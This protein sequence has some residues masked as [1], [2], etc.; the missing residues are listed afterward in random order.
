MLK[1][2]Q[3]T[4]RVEGTAIADDCGQLSEQNAFQEGGKTVSPLF[5]LLLSML[6]MVGMNAQAQKQME[7]LGRGVVAVRS[8]S[9][10]VYVSWRMFGTD[11]SNI[12]FN[13]YRGTTKL[14]ASPITNSTNYVDN[15]STN[16]T[17]SVRPVINGV[18]QTASAS[19]SVWGQ[20]F[21]SIPIQIPAGGSNASGAYTYA[22]G[23]ASVGDLDG[24]GEYEIVLKWDPSNA[25]DNSQS[26]YTGNVYIDAYKLNGT[27]LWR[28][29]LGRN[30]RAGAHYTQLMV[31]DLDGDGKAEI[32][33]KTGDGTRDGRGTVI[34]NANADYRNSSGYILTGPEYLTIFNG[35]TGA[36]MATTAHLPARGDVC[37]W[38][39]NECYGNRVDRFVSAVAYLD[40]QRPSLIIG[41]GYYGK[42]VRAAYDW[43]N[44]QLTRRWI[45]DSSASGNSAYAGQGNHQ[46]SV[47]DVDGDG[48]DEVV[49][50]SSVID[51]NGAG[52]WSNRLGHG[53]ALH[54]SDMDP[55]RPGQEI[56]MPYESPSSNGGTGMALVNASNGSIIWRVPVA[57]GDIGR[58]IAADIDPRHKGYEM[59]GATGNLYN[60]KGAQI[61]TTKPSMNFAIWWDG[62]LS[63]EILDGTKLD[64]WN[65]NTNSVDRLMTIYNYGTATQINGTKANPCLSAD[66]LGD[67][68]EEMI[69]RS[70]DNTKLL[71]FTTT[72]PTT[73]RIYTLM[74]DPQYRVAIAWQNTAY[75][76]PPHPGFYLGTGMAAAPRPNI[77]LVGDGPTTN[78]TGGITSGATYTIAARH[79]GQ[80]VDVAGASTA[81]GANIE[82]YPS[83]NGTNQQ[84]VVTST[85]DGYYTLKAVHSGRNLT[86]EGS[87]TANG[88]NIAQRTASAS[89]TNQQF[90]LVD[91]GGGYYNIKAR[92]SGRCVDVVEASTANSANINQWACG[93]GTNQQFSFTKV[94]GARLGAATATL[95]NVSVHP[96]PSSS[97]FRIQVIGEFSY[98]VYDQ[99]G[100][101]V[102]SGKGQDENSVGSN[103]PKGLYL[104]KIQQFNQTKQVKVIKQ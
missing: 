49:N 94:G 75:N 66:L 103:L 5:I 4:C 104:I 92:H 61:S 56:W 21:L 59:W 43:R 80:V 45:F 60:A 8:S 99:L 48:R 88:A 91:V 58:G 63:R 47:G 14:N 23:D 38:G 53:D 26:G 55:D 78:P 70:A 65:P 64:K 52:K 79:S 31:Y 86:V 74:H 37:S 97:T 32:A 71:L 76:Q 19:A 93:T 27:R 39:N 25:K 77:V 28:I 24:D 82:Q 42:L 90:Q 68:R 18:E 73:N 95:D 30:I 15:T 3:T 29:D 81:D 89:A 17:Y 16:A 67:W 13:V 87:S 84:W 33:C 83:R 57:S 72:I 102:E 9:S 100:K 36:A 54:M 51:D 40:G 98:T 44:G 20:Q 10:Q 96:N 50:G 6:L 35:Q 101:V 85:G 12:A 7:R 22:A 69:Y 41:R 46:L 62:D 11:P 1:H 2:R 34:G